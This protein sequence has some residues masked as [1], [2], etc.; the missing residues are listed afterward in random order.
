MQHISIDSFAP[1]P[2]A[3]PSPPR[4]ALPL[5]TVKVSAGFLFLFAVTAHAETFTGYVVGV[6]DG[7]T[8]T[9][10]DAKRRQHK[11]RVSGIDAPEK[12]QPFG[13]RSKENLSGLVFGKDVLV[14]W[15]KNDRYRRIVG[16][17]WVQ[18]LD[19]PHCG[20][21]LD[22]GQAQLVAGMAWWYRKYANEQSPEDRAQ[23]EF[24]EHEARARR[25]GLWRDPEP[26][27]PWIWRKNRRQTSD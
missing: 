7:D 9:V 25:T 18:P 3:C 1:F 14:E 24:E 8:V 16:K 6:A 11:I 17:I 13:K 4:V 20:L 21:T 15:I 2:Q 23:Y 26:V 27:P 5:D 10:I 19:C 12:A 22:A